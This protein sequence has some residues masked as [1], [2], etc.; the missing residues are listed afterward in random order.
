MIYFSDLFG[1]VM[2]GHVVM[3]LSPAALK[4][5]KGFTNDSGCGNETAPKRLVA[6]ATNR[7]ISGRMYSLF[8]VALSSQCLSV[9]PFGVFSYSEEERL[10]SSILESGFRDYLFL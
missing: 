8:R 4:A 9:C 6:R 7:S 5:G 10:S 3:S 1:S 2:A